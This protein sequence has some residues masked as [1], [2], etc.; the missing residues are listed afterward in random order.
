MPPVFLCDAMLGGLARWLRAAGY[1]AEFDV[2]MKDGELVRRGTEEEKV[3]VTSD[4]DILERYAVQ[5]EL[6]QTVYLPPG[7]TP[8][9]QLSRVLQELQL[10]LRP[11]R[12]MECGGELEEVEKNAVEEELPAAVK[13]RFEEFFQCAACRKVY[14]KGSHWSDIREKLEWAAGKT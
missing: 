7:L 4:S 14:W 2:Q 11:P 12:C 13:E 5:N 8:L 1:R 9:E 6:V 10:K 3:I